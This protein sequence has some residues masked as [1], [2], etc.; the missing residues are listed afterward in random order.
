M[1]RTIKTT[2]RVSQFAEKNLKNK[3]EFG[4]DA[5][6]AFK[7]HL[8]DLKRSEKDDPAFPYKF[9]PEKAEDI[10]AYVG[11]KYLAVYPGLEGKYMSALCSSA[12]G[13]KL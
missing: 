13:V 2:D 11:E 5:R 3:K 12:D 1:S 7:R 8:D 6:L 4:E 9:V 10:L